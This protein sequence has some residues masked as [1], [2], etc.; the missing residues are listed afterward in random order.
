[1]VLG[2]TLVALAQAGL[3]FAPEL[4]LFWG[5]LV[6]LGTSFSFTLGMAA[7]AEIAP[8]ERVGSVAGVLLA[9]GYLGSL[10]GPLGMGALRDLSG[11]F[12]AS[13]AFLAGL[14]I[15]MAVASAALPGRR[16]G[17]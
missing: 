14:G 17:G 1:M 13:L 2:G 6:G 3:A 9:I 16:A 11:G 15:A 10:V 4:G 8:R 5:A 12:G 7:P